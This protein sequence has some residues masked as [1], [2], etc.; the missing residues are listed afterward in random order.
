MQ[1]AMRGLKALYQTLLLNILM[2][3]VALAQEDGGG[4]GASTCSVASGIGA[5]LG[6]VT[7]FATLGAL[8]FPSAVGFVAISIIAGVPATGLSLGTWLGCAE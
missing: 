5:V 6:T 4:G 3:Q 8:A 7:F 1:R 2:F